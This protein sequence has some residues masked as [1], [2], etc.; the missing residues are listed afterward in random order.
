MTVL[1][2]LFVFV[3]FNHFCSFFFSMQLVAGKVQKQDRQSK[4]LHLQ[5]AVETVFS[6]CE[7]KQNV[8]EGRIRSTFKCDDGLNFSKLLGGLQNVCNFCYNTLIIDSLCP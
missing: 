1:D 3:F 2:F 7:M 4:T 5:T 8:T 6:P